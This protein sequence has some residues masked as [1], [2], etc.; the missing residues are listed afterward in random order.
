MS[1]ALA[2][3]IFAERVMRLFATAC[4]QNKIGTSA[5][6]SRGRGR[7]LRLAQLIPTALK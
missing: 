4:L 6:A 7:M 1:T 3:K 2:S 5:S